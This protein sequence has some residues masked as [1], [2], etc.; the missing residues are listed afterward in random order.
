MKKLFFVAAAFI[1]SV[2]AMAQQKADEVLK[3][4]TEKFDFG[5]IKQNVPVTTYFT[6][7]NKSDKPIV[8]ENAWASCGCTTPEYP[9]PPIAPGASA[10]VKVGYNAAALNGFTKEVYIKLAGVQE[11][12]VVRITGEVLEAAAYATYAKQKKTSAAATKKS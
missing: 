11:P 10:K 4:N 7:T 6:I 12:K 8:V 2:A 1:V 3:V 5:K 9:K